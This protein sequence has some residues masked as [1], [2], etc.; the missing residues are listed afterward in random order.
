MT[1]TVDISIGTS[2]GPQDSFEF[3]SSSDFKSFVS[4]S[5]LGVYTCAGAVNAN[6]VISILE[7]VSITYPSS[8]TPGCLVVIKSDA[9]Q[10][11][12]EIIDSTT[13]GVSGATIQPTYDN[14]EIRLQIPS[15]SNTA[16]TSSGGSLSFTVQKRVSCGPSDSGCSP[17]AKL[18]MAMKCRR[19]CVDTRVRLLLVT[20]NHH[21]T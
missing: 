7:L 17:L 12:Y 3:T 1:G 2:S 5:A 10:K 9:L 4:N 6:G 11:P 16:G 8:P 13:D 18:A 14:G 21:C 20:S 15:R 19:L